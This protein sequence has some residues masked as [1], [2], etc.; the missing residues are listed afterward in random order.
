MVKVTFCA[1]DKPGNVGGPVTWI[2]RLLPDLRNRGIDVRCLFLLHCGDTGPAL[3]SLRKQGIE[4]D[5]VLAPARTQDGVTWILDRLAENPPD[6]FVPNLVLAGYFASRWARESA[7]ATVGVL[8]SDDDY[9]RGLQSEFLSGTTAFRLSGV[10]CVSSELE[11]Q[12]LSRNVDQLVVRRIP[13]GVPIPAQ[14]VIRSPGCLRLAFVGRL[15]EEQKRIAELTRALCRAAQQINGVEATIYGDGPDRGEVERILREERKGAAVRL[16]GPV[17]SDEMQVRLLASDI[18]VLLSDYEGLPMGLMEAMACGS[19]P[20]CLRIRSGIPELVTDGVTGLLV[21]DRGDDFLRAIR[22]L[23]DDGGLWQQLSDGAR[24]CVASRFSDVQCSADWS[25][26][27][28]E[29]AR[30]TVGRRSIDVPRTIRLPAVNPLLTPAD[31]RSDGPPLSVRAYRRGRM[32]AGLI[33]RRLMARLGS[34]DSA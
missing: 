3:E 18:I 32:L 2:Q 20:V 34:Q 12:V 13:C 31:I 26:M 24:S 11:R 8:H 9:Y 15:A 10:V 27:L 7:V 33:R 29:I 21:N 25:K 17:P 4:C 28:E 23:R 5:A 30:P 14:R 22:R 19:V 1:Y 6:V 16:H